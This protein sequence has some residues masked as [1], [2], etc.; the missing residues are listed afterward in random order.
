MQL[1][2]NL[3]KTFSV[4]LCKTAADWSLLSYTFFRYLHNEVMLQGH[5]QSFTCLWTRSILFILPYK[6]EILKATLDSV[7]E[8]FPHTTVFT[9][10]CLVGSVMNDNSRGNPQLSSG[11]S[12]NVLEEGILGWLCSAFRWELGL[13]HLKASMKAT[14][15]QNF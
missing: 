13:H 7:S 9:S 11:P 3:I 1:K 4:L 12:G 8:V 6:K 15:V 10:S 2:T 5:I 14:L